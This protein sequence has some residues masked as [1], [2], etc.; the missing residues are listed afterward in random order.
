MRAAVFSASG[1]PVQQVAHKAVGCIE[2]RHLVRAFVPPEHPRVQR[3]LYDLTEALKVDAG[4]PLTPTIHDDACPFQEIADYT[5]WNETKRI[6]TKQ[7]GVGTREDH[8][9]VDWDLGIDRAELGT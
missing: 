5:R 7:V 2:A 6:V 3:F 4:L 8:A 9:Q 1:W